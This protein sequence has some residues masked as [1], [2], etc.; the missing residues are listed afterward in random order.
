MGG[1][2]GGEVVLGVDGLHADVRL[3]PGDPGRSLAKRRLGEI[4][5]TPAGGKIQ[6]TGRDILEYLESVRVPT[7]SPRMRKN[8]WVKTKGSI[9]FSDSQL[10]SK[11]EAGS[12]IVPGTAEGSDGLDEQE[13]L[14][15]LLENDRKKRR[16][17]RPSPGCSSRHQSPVSSGSDRG[18]ELSGAPGVGPL[19]P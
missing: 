1:A 16:T 6:D 17:R 9:K 7:T 8:S 4:S 10:T 12:P 14:R 19:T 18:N 3:P 11:A 15:R 5:D 2:E 13:S